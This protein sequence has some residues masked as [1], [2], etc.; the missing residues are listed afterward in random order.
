MSPA[1][2]HCCDAMR[3]ELA[4]HGG[5]G[6]SRPRSPDSLLEYVPK[7]D[8]YG[9]VVHDGGSSMVQIQFC[10]WCGARLPDSKRDR[11]FDELEKLGINPLSDPIPRDFQTNAWYLK[12]N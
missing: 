12:V 8:E 3:T 10:P 11:W 5:E 4:R 1:V 7:Y 2:S 9:I 6:T